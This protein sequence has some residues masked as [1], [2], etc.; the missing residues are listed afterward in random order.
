MV[1]V[2][3]YELVKAEKT[4]TSFEFSK[5]QRVAMICDINK[6]VGGLF[7]IMEMANGL[8]RMS[9]MSHRAARVSAAVPE[10]TKRIV[11]STSIAGRCRRVF[12]GW[13][14]VFGGS[15]RPDEL[16]LWIRMD[17]RRTLQALVAIIIK[18]PYCFSF[19]SS[20]AAPDHV[21]LLAFSPN[22]G[23][24]AQASLRS[25]QRRRKPQVRLGKRHHPP[26]RE[27]S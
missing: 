3:W 9:I 5:A 6:N 19:V 22:V 4:P 8:L 18:R 7:V 1:D 27:E 14:C 17:D 2:P 11:L 26:R 16:C 24:H 13:L 15:R 10:R 20:R 12:L 21:F 25:I 23:C